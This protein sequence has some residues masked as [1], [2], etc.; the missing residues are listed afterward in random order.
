MEVAAQ[1]VEGELDGAETDPVAAAVDSRTAGFDPLSG[2]DRQM[3][4]LLAIGTAVSTLAGLLAPYVMGSVVET[5]ATPLNGFRLSE[6]L[7][8]NRLPSLTE[9]RR[10]E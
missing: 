5:A 3:D 6:S 2:G 7:P 8:S 1:A 4:A 9:A 10:R